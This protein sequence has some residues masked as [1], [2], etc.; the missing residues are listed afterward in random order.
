MRGVVHAL[1]PCMS[2]GWAS[3]VPGAVFSTLI[4]MLT[5]P[6]F[7]SVIVSGAIAPASRVFLRPSSM[8]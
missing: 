2:M 5:A 3:A 8:M 6:A 7:A 1:M 4:S